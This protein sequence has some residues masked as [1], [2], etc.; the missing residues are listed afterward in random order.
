[1]YGRCPPQSALAFFLAC[2]DGGELGGLTSEGAWFE[3]L[4]FPFTYTPLQDVARSL[5]SVQTTSND[6]RV[7]GR[8]TFSG[9]SMRPKHGMVG[10]W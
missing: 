8:L 3:L 5:A 6:R 9:P 4:Y 1:M 10:G 7:G 2:L